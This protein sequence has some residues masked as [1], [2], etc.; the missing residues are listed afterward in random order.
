MLISDLVIIAK[1]MRATDP[2]NKQGA[3]DSD[4]NLDNIGKIGAKS[5]QMQQNNQPDPNPEKT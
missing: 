4:P 3:F 5:G 2:E 1:M